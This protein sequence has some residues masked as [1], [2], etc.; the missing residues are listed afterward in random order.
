M[1]SVNNQ[2]VSSA[3][4]VESADLAVSYDS[5]YTTDGITVYLYGTD[6]ATVDLSSGYYGTA[7][8]IDATYSSGNNFLVGNYSSN[9]IVA[10]S[11]STA[12]W[13]GPDYST[14]VLVGGWGY[15]TFY[16][17]KYEGTDYVLNASSLDTVNL[18]NTS[19]YDIIQTQYDGSSLTLFFNTGTALVVACT[20]MF[21]PTFVTADGG[22]YA[23]NR[24]TY[25]WQ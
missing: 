17:G 18:Y 9:N 10:G 24:A 15:D 22:R 4:V 21:S 12:L 8:N 3:D 19:V 2:L 11:N 14:D 5:S 23:F 1:E 25:Q 7:V 20:D 6:A 13:G 16:C